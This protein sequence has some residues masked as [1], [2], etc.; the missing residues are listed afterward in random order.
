MIEEALTEKIIGCAYEVY[1]S[2]GS[3]FLESVYHNALTI[4]LEEQC[5]DVKSEY[6]IKVLFREKI[7]GNFY[8][9]LLVE[10]KII[11]EI[12]AIDHLAKIHEI[13]IV[14]YLKATG[15]DIGLLINFG[16][17]NIQVK[18]KYRKPNMEK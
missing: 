7:I 4:A 2:L 15:L 5:I 3:G 10:D 11:I 8:A 1:N 9:D 13:Q 14:N 12:K 6:P 17:E 18:R 16:T